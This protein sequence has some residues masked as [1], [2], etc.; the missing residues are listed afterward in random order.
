MYSICSALVCGTYSSQEEI[1]RFVGYHR[2]DKTGNVIAYYRYMC[3]YARLAS[4]DFSKA[5][6]HR[7]QLGYCAEGSRSGGD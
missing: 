2:R 5:G 1:V 6:N 3:D 4:D 7:Q